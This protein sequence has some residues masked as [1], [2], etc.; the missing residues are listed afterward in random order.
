ML[1]E[2]FVEHLEEVLP[3]GGKL[4][5][6]GS[7]Q[8][9]AVVDLLRRRPDIAYRG[10]EPSA[11]AHRAARETLAAFRN[12]ELVCGDGYDL[13]EAN[14]WDVCFSL[15]VLEHVKQLQ[16]FLSESIRSVKSGG[17]IVHRWDLGHALTPSSPKERLQVFL[18]DVFPRVLPEHKFVRHLGLRE[19]SA[20]ME[21]GG[22]TVERTTFH[23]MPDHKALLKH[24][25][26]DTP[27]KAAL[28][29]ELVEWEFKVSPLLGDV[30]ERAREKLFPAI[31]VWA[32]KR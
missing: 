6:L 10:V 19:V 4:L 30:P 14:S 27:E 3:A 28:I 18:G 32:K 23:Q 12:A 20:I 22:A 7:G 29:R 8:S 2:I 24:F 5:E 21:G 15:S 25:H 17:W 1:K 9:R 26:P 11:A 31:A 13:G 16:R